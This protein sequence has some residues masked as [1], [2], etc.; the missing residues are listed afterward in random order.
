[1]FCQERG[2]NVF[3]LQNVAPI[4]WSTQMEKSDRQLDTQH[5]ADDTSEEEMR[6]H[7]LRM[8]PEA[9]MQMRLRR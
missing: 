4:L 1:M 8:M 5:A 9:L 6:S 3:N 2:V 7:H